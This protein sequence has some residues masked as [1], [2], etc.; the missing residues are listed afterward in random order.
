MNVLA[1]RRRPAKKP[2][3][4]DELL[5]RERLDELLERS[6]FVVLSLPLTPE[7]RGLIGARELR[8]MKKTAYLL[9]VGRGEHVDE[10]ALVRALRDKSIAGAGLD[11]FQTE[12]L[13]RRSKLWRAPNLLVSPHY[14]GTYPEHMDRAADLFAENLK[15]FLT[16]RT[17]KNLVD[18]KAGY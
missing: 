12:P 1:I 4:V 6:D 15:R 14:S 5:G 2:R 17:L 10:A 9:N 16:K 3:F 11:V 8:K 18:K 13:P 7:T